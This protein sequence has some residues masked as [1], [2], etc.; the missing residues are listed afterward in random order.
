MDDSRTA[1]LSSQSG[2][3]TL[4]QKETLAADARKSIPSRPTSFK[5]A[6]GSTQDDIQKSEPRSPTEKDTPST[7]QEWISGIPLFAAITGVTLVIFLMLLD[8]SIVSTAIPRIT[9]E[10]HSLQDVAWYGSAYTLA[11]CALQPLTGKFYTH[12]TTKW[13]FLG[14]FG[15]FELGS[16]ICGLANS[17]KMLIVGRAV[18]GMG[19]SG[20]VNGAMTII[21]GALPM[22]RRPAMIGI[23]MGVSQLGLVLG[24]L[25]GGAFTTYT[26]WR[27]CFY[28][29]LPIGALVAVLLVF[30]HIPEQRKKGRAVEVLPTF[31]KTFDLVGF[32]LFAPA[33]IMFLLALEYG[34]NKY[35]WNSSTVI[36]LFCGAGATCI[37]FLIWEYRTGE[38]AMIPFHLI[39]PRIAYSSYVSMMTMFGMT[40]VMTYYLPIYF[41]AVRG[42]SAL[43]SGVDLLPNVLCQLVMAVVSG[44]LTGKLGYYLPWAVFG[45]MLNAIGSGL[46]ATLSPTTPTRD[47]AGF[48]AL[49]GFGRGASTQAPM[50]AV[51]NA[52]SP[53]E[54]STAM[55]ILTFSQ[56]FG[57]SVFLAV[58]E[59]IFSNSLKDTIPKYA[60]NVDPNTVI[61]A[62]ATGFRDV[63]SQQ[64]LPGVLSA[65]AKSIDRVFYLAAALAVV[66]FVASWGLGWKDISQK[67]DEP[68]DTEKGEIAIEA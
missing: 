26:T 10:F 33:A 61:A 65:Y 3:D 23:M 12:F 38:G 42:H 59:V 22:H 18:A 31:F 11:S 21:A 32:V 41:Q 14:F 7:E 30:T 53:D 68:K 17:S 60:P 16:L 4:M 50:I 47:W 48:Q 62:G 28:I 5:G 43:V 63:I 19:T 27:W 39:R 2:S 55:A 56:T 64:D 8:T 66:Q 58:A 29:N 15:V 54:V 40:M 57:G 67:K 49:F 37:I 45:S 36:G 9:N 20:M 44:V 1:T 24:P 13:V 51:Q 46:L 52:I 25:I 35:A 34:G 6:S